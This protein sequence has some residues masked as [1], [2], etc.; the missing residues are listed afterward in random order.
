M[1]FIR[2]VE[3]TTHPKETVITLYVDNRYRDNIETMLQDI[4]CDVEYD[5]SVKKRRNKRSLDANAYAWVLIGK[6]AQKLNKSP[7]EIYRELIRDM[8]TYNI[9]PVRDDA[10]GHFIATWESHGLGWMVIVMG[11]SK[12][13]GYTNLKCHYGSSSFTTRDMSQ[14]IDNIIA[15]CKVQ[16]IEYISN[17]ELQ[18][19]VEDW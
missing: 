11:Q 7:I 5:L 19:L 2:P 10:V 17:E 8:P 14:F 3:L 6:L 4:S 12:F 9:L 13:K 1:R 16:G 15:E 18:R